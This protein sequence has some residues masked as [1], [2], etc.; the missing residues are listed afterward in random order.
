MLQ[1]KLQL[2]Y[3]TKIA[4]Q[5]KNSGESV[6]KCYLLI[7]GQALENYLLEDSKIILEINGN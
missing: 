6:Q 4:R 5:K 2:F 7:Q 3:F 1:K